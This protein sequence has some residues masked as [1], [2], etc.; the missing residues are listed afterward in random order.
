[1]IRPGRARARRQPL[2]IGHRFVCFLLVWIPPL[3]LLF[4]S[5]RT[6]VERLDAVLEQSAPLVSAEA[7]RALGR[8]VRV[9]RLTTDWSVRS[10]WLLAR[11]LPKMQTLSITAEDLAIANG[12]TLAAAGPLATARRATVLLD[13]PR[14]LA[15]DTATMVARIVVESPR[16]L[17]VRRASGTFNV[18]DLVRPRTGPPRKPFQTLITLRDGHLIFRDFAARLPVERRPAVNELIAVN[19]SVDLTGTRRIRFDIGGRARPGTPTMERLRGALELRGSLARSPESDGARALVSVRARDAAAA[20]WTDY[21]FDLPGVVAT[22]GWVDTDLSLVYPPRP[23]PKT[24]VPTQY[25]GTVRLRRGRVSLPRLFAPLG[26]IA[27][28]VRFDRVAARVAG[29]ASLV[30]EKVTVEG[31]LWNLFGKDQQQAGASGPQ[32]AISVAMPRAPVPRVIAAFLPRG[33]R[34]PRDLTLAGM[35]AVTASVHGTTRNPVATARVALPTLIYRRVRAQQ[36]QGNVTYSRGTLTLTEVTGRVAGGGLAGR[37]AIQIARVGEDGI[38]ETLPSNARRAAF[39]VQVDGVNLAQLPIG[40]PNPASG[41]GNLE[42]I[43]KL[44]DGKLTVAANLVA[45]RASVRGI[46]VR[47]ARARVLLLNNRILIPGLFAA[48]SAGAARVAGNVSPTGKLSLNVRAVGLDVGRI[49]RALGRPDIHGVAYASGSIRGSVNSPVLSAS[50]RVFAPGYRGYRADVATG[51]ITATRTRITLGPDVTIRR[52]PATATVS[53]AVALGAGPPRLALTARVRNVALTE[54][55]RQL[56]QDTSQLPPI[57]GAVREANL[58]IGGSGVRPRVTASLALGDLLVGEYAVDGGRVDLAFVDGATTVRNAELSVR[59]VGRLIASA[60]LTSDGRL[61]GNF[62]LPNM[63]LEPLNPLVRRYAT[64]GGS[65]SVTGSFEGTRTNPVLRAR[66]TSERVVVAGTPLTDLEAELRYVTNT[67]T[68]DARLFVPA[69]SFR[70]NGTTV[71]A[72]DVLWDRGSGR[73]AAALS[74][75]TGDIAVLLDTVRRSGLADTDAGAR[76]VAALNRLPQP[77]SGNFSIQTLSLRGRLTERGIEERTAQVAF[78]AAN[79]QIGQARVDSLR[80]AGTLDGD[81][82]RLDEFVATND[83]TDTTILARGRADLNGDMDLVLE[84]NNA[85]LALVRAFR[86]SLRLD[87]RVDLTVA[88]RGRTRTPT[89]TASLSG[90]DISLGRAKLSLLRVAGATLHPVAD[91]ATGAGASDLPP[92]VIDISEVLLLREGHQARI[93]GTLPFDYGSFSIPSNGTIRLRAEAR[94]QDLDVL[95]AL[96]PGLSPDAVSGLLNAQLDV[97]GTL[98]APRLSGF[99]Q[100]TDGRFTPP[101]DPGQTRDPINPIAD[102]DIDIGFDGTAVTFRRFDLALGG[103]NGQR[104]DFGRM[105]LSG[106]LD[107]A[108]LEFAPRILPT[109]APGSRILRGGRVNLVASLQNLRPVEEDLLNLGEAVRGRINGDLHIT[110]SLAQ[111][112][113]QTRDGNPLVLDDAVLQ[114]PT[115]QSTGDPT[116]RDYPMNPVFAIDVAIGN[117]AVIASAGNTYRVETDGGGSIG[118]TL[119]DPVVR[120]TLQVLGGYFRLPTALFRVQRGGTVTLALRPPQE[121]IIQVADFVARTTLYTRAGIAPTLG[122]RASQGIFASADRPVAGGA[123]SYRITARLDGPLLNLDPRN[124][125]LESDPPLERSQIFSLIGSEQQIALAASGDVERA[126][127]LQ[128]SQVVNSSLVPTL[129]SPIE[130]SVAS[131]LGL[132]EFGLEY[133][134]DVPLTLRF[135]KRFPDPFERF[136]IAFTRSVGA[137]SSNPG[138]PQP[139]NLRLY[140][141]LGPR[142]QIGISTD[143][144]REQTVFLRGS[145][146]F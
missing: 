61:S 145:L 74:L 63:N 135:V 140:Y 81:L 45:R 107:I 77:I 38:L 94:E 118:G 20:Y 103:P 5:G 127:A 115:R 101:R 28:E 100:L 69:L 75:Q 86:P 108:D 136:L 105:T 116:A 96:M 17:L 106:S 34:L 12:P 68:G 54:I 11:R 80:V 9:G 23:D 41:H 6:V 64:L 137:R 82:I 48:T 52:F 44:A 79:V 10:L 134:L 78:S 113:I 122:V 27:A 129:L 66:V 89:V 36:L 93:T 53:G 18:Q 65:A 130:T 121:P 91:P 71:R 128:F 123:T 21:L 141:E 133:N 102:L 88:A 99:F 43:G 111:P 83:A 131:A 67:R 97:G 125:E 30:G 143:E 56:G 92:G 31:V 37:A 22:A 139:Y 15:G 16:V 138:F 4:L 58:R 144:Q 95:A 32:M 76:I 62:S 112:T 39:S 42:A 47:E 29:T 72:S 126:L 55:L 117:K 142:L 87:G 26:E 33:Q 59:N 114:M 2:G 98:S 1:M 90:R 120:A 85:S 60:R 110:G 7:S 109:G 119:S 49:A 57:A 84:S 104:G 51:S 124:L 14:L 40:G 35:G 8:E 13:V 46:A 25:L 24:V 132:E 50:L 19:G 146:S 73:I 3:V 70:Q